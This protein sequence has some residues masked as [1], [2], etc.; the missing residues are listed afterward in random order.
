MLVSVLS[1]RVSS[2]RRGEVVWQGVCSAVRSALHAEEFIWLRAKSLS[3][4]NEK[5]YK[6]NNPSV[7]VLP[8]I[9][10]CTKSYQLIKNSPNHLTHPQVKHW[11][12]THTHTHTHKRNVLFMKELPD[13]LQVSWIVRIKRVNVC[14]E[15]LEKHTKSLKCCFFFFRRNMFIKIKFI[16]TYNTLYTSLCIVYG[17]KYYLYCDTD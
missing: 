1:K 2:R 13:I 8:L 10:F 14:S 4:F 6:H 17:L 16:Q 12:D 5:P 9:D 11:N 7:W 3:L 15:T